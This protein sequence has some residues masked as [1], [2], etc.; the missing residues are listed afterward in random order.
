MSKLESTLNSRRFRLAVI[1]AVCVFF[2][3]YLGIEITDEM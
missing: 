1:S 2:S 3:E